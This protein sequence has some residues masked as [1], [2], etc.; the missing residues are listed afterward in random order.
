MFL[1]QV[2][3]LQQGKQL[4][5]HRGLV[6]GNYNYVASTLGSPETCQEPLAT[7]LQGETSRQVGCDI[8]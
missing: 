6:G 3:V 4:V 7:N 1:Q 8:G 5:H 2:L